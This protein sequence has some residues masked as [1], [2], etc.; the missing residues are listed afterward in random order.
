L[1]SFGHHQQQMWSHF[2]YLIP[3]LK[4][5]LNINN[6]CITESTSLHGLSSTTPNHKSR[7]AF[8]YTCTFI[9]N[10]VHVNIVETGWKV[11]SRTTLPS[12]ILI[13]YCSAI[14][15]YCTDSRVQYCVIYG[16]GLQYI[17]LSSRQIEEHWQH[18][19]YPL[20]SLLRDTLSH[21]SR[22][23]E[24]SP[25][26]A[27]LQRTSC[28]LLPYSPLMPFSDTLSWLSFAVSSQG[29]CGPLDWNWKW[30]V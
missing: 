29:L 18:S 22:A 2:H 13:T 9:Q 30:K 6:K 5:L 4:G 26:V 10:H 24:I 3:S 7:N 27:P 12:Y 1:T 28:S 15:Y 20:P 23:C 14:V 11:C 16:I 8:R 19:W 25:P 21:P 17:Y